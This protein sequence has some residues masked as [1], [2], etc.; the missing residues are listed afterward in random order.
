MVSS[1]VTVDCISQK[2][3]YFL[4]S[5]AEFRLLSPTVWGGDRS[6]YLTFA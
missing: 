5:K 2:T 6:D 4:S 1:V 3:W